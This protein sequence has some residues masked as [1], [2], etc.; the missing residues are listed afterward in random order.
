MTVVEE[1]FVM[2]SND[3]WTMIGN[4]LFN[5]I[6]RTKVGLFVKAD[7][8]SWSSVGIFH[9]NKYLLLFKENGSSAAAI[10]HI[11]LFLC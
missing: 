4:E 2:N 6:G 9:V 3:Y 8:N 1:M 10:H 7:R 11:M 5:S